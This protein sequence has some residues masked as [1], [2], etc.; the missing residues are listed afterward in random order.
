MTGQHKGGRISQGRNGDPSRGDFTATQTLFSRRTPSH[1]VPKSKPPGHCGA[2]RGKGSTATLHFAT[3]NT[4]TLA[5][6]EDLEQLQDQL[7][8]FK[9]SVIGL[10]ETYRKG[11][12]SVELSDG[13]W[14]YG[15]GRTEESPNTKGLAFLVHKDI[16]DYIESFDKH[17]DRISCKIRLQ[18]ELLQL[19]E[20]YTPTT[21]Y[22]NVD[23][24]I[25]YEELEKALDPKCK[26]KVI[27]GDFNSKIGVKEADEENEWI[28]PFGIGE[29]NERGERLIDFCVANKLYI[30]NSF[31][32][33]PTSRYW[34]WESP[35]GR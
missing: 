11:E 8:G 30:T 27:I 12:G 34:T 1:E 23:F 21:E 26:Y 28:G 33:K 18:G 17:S 25:F 4:K 2:D 31:Y 13:S 9:W 35:G 14:L 5:S 29:R 32:Q 20:T 7:K 15:A 10:C 6:Q 19:I 3:Y 22:D 16:K 24:E